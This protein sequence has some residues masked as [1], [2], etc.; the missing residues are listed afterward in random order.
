MAG[1]SVVNATAVPFTG[2]ANT[3]VI[4]KALPAGSFVLTGAATIAASSTA[5]TTP[6]DVT[7]SISDSGSTAAYTAEF[8]GVT[9]GASNTSKFTLPLTLAVT[10]AAGNTAKIAC[11][12]V[13]NGGNGYGVSATSASLT[14]V[15]TT[16]NS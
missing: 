1:F 10:S 15:Q 16:S 9:N 13:S 14:A 5:A 2:S 4:A 8:A 3:Q 12:D 11:S 7:C 6:F